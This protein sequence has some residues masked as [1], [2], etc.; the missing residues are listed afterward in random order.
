M[1]PGHVPRGFWGPPA[2][3]T[4]PASNRM[5]LPRLARFEIQGQRRW[6]DF[7]PKLGS[8]YRNRSDDLLI[9]GEKTYQ[10]RQDPTQSRQVN[11]V[12]GLAANRPRHR[13]TRSRADAPAPDGPQRRTPPTTST[14][15]GTR[16]DGDGVYPHLLGH[17]DPRNNAL[18]RART[19]RRTGDRQTRPQ[20]ALDH[21][22]LHRSERA[23]LE[24]LVLVA[25]D[26]E[27]VRAFIMHA[28]D[29]TGTDLARQPP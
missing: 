12:P 1:T 22:R 20:P 19:R 29:R 3:D 21:A 16:F 23:A 26:E 8:P 13:R 28:P 10:P 6:L 2:A 4:G 27:P 14:R 24:E 15:E 9:A 5:N 18:H 17:A 11:A 25:R 7:A